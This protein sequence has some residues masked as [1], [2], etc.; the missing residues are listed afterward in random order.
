M[1]AKNFARAGNAVRVYW[2]NVRVHEGS[3][4]WSVA[5]ESAV[6][7]GWA[8]DVIGARAVNFAGRVFRAFGNRMGEMK[9]LYGCS[10]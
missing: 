9:G 10:S 8:G 2:R 7:E 4:G 1:A 3:E 6:C 5:Q